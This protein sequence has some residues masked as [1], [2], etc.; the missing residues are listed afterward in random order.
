MISE[1]D[2]RAEQEGKIRSPR[3]LRENVRTPDRFADIGRRP[4]QAKQIKK[5][6][7]Q[8]EIDLT[9]PKDP[10]SVL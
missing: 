2:K 7:Q 3:K 6:K 9:E 4:R 8:V 10:L 1:Y 5:A